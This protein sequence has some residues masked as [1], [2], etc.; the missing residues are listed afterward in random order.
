MQQIAENV[1]EVTYPL[2]LIGAQLGRRVTIIRLAS[3]KLIIHSTGPFSGQDIGAIKALGA[4]AWLIDVTL[5]HDTFADIGRAAF[6]EVPYGVPDGFIHI[7][8]ERFSLNTPPPEWGDEFQIREVEGMPRVREYACFHSPSR[9]LIIADLVFNF[10]C[11]SAW[12]RQFFRW[13]GGIKEYPG[14]SRLFRAMIK[15]R[16]AFNRSIEK[17]LAWDFD[18]LVVAHGQTIVTGTR[19][20]LIRALE[21][22]LS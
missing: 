9:T 16:T 1:Y 3:G 6:P 14:M 8:G 7:D 21:T 22:A 15:D 5:N 13:A 10:E 2:S 12:T 17:I 11:C 18:R 4:P 20:R 19:P